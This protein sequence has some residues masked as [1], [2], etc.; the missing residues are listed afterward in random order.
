[1]NKIIL[2][3]SFLTLMFTSAVAG[4]DTNKVT[5][6][7]Q[8]P[9]GKY[10]TAKQAFKIVNSDGDEVLFVDVRT[11]AE[12]VFV[13]MT[14]MTDTNIPYMTQDIY[15]W[16]DKKKRFSMEANSN[17]SI[18]FED[19]LKNKGLNKN[20]KIILMCRSGSRSAKAANLLNS[21]GYQ[22]VYSVIDGFEG[23]KAK[24][25][26]NKG[27]RV[28]NGWKNSNLPWSY[29]LSKSKMYFE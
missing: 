7:K 23:D 12:T 25:G 1:M 4:V 3:I 16:D 5:K 18:A 15:S 22:N 24:A 17:F 11:R 19:A 9:Q 27:H 26:P 8:T 2:G 13:G 14:D 10:L 21:L 20:S 28:V 6:K 29:K